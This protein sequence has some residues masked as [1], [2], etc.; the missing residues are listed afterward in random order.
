MEWN[1][2][3]TLLFSYFISQ[4]LKRHI[5]SPVGILSIYYYFLFQFEFDITNIGGWYK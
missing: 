5:I 4:Q 3:K 1:E 2:G